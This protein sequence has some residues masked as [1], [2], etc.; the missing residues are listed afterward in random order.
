MSKWSDIYQQLW[1]Q[2]LEQVLTLNSGQKHTHVRTE[3]DC[4]RIK[5]KFY[6]KSEASIGNECTT[7]SLS[8]TQQPVLT[9]SAKSLRA[10]HVI[11][12]EN[13]YTWMEIS[14]AL[15]NNRLILNA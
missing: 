3:R 7:I 6:P 1:V 15:F 11:K 12:Q 10:S 13:S 4:M 14:K 9:I 2:R 5:P 8:K